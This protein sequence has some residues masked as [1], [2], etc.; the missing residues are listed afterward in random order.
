MQSDIELNVRQFQAVR[1]QLVD[2]KPKKTLRTNKRKTLK[3]IAPCVAALAPELL[4]RTR[5][6]DY[7]GAETGMI[8][9][10]VLVAA[11]LDL[12]R[13]IRGLKAGR[14]HPVNPI[15]AGMRRTA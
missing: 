11:I 15:G 7:V 14:I 6:I 12:Q 9:S 5:D 4:Y 10:H 2:G 13:E 1:L 3:T 8:A